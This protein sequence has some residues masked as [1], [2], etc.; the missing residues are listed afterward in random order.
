MDAVNNEHS[1][2]QEWQW[3]L[4]ANIVD[5]HEYGE[6]HEI[7]HGTK[8]FRPG[9]KVF[10]NL[11]YGGMGHEYILVIGT[12]RHDPG[13]IE[14]VIR[15]KYVC[16]FRVQKVYKPAVLRRMNESVW[17]WWGNTDEAYDNLVKILEW[18]NPEEA[19][20]EKS[21]RKNL[22]IINYFES[23]DR[24]HW[25]SEIKKSDW[26]AASTLVGFLENGTF[27]ENLGDG[28]LLLLTDGDKLV[29]FVTFAQRDCIDD[30]S[31][32]P[33]IGF[34]YT[35]PEY[36]GHRYAGRLI[37]CCEELAREHNVKNIYICTDHIGLYEKYGYTYKESR[38]DIYGG[39]S[40]IYVKRI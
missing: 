18:L 15:R 14:V 23:N 5:E 8:H 10:V 39:D 33:W 40:R 32:S 19:E 9:A 3:C 16:N 35:F 6:A 12:P 11:V 29:S 24:E 17:D 31:L 37:E 25:L 21:K 36:R 38:V 34:V 13:Y 30:K 4:V 28:V 26:R 2:E 22:E 7:K 1:A 20:K 27:F